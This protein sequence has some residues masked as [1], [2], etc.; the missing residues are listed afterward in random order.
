MTEENLA[1][2]S[3]QIEDVANPQSVSFTPDPKEPAKEPVKPPT[4]REA[5]EK[6]LAD[7]EAKDGKRLPDNPRDEKPE[8]KKADKETP[9][10]VKD[11]APAKDR[12]PDGKFA[13][14]Q[15]ENPQ[16]PQPENVNSNP[17]KLDAPK[18]PQGERDINRAPDN[19]LP[20]A[21]E[22]WAEAPEEVRGE[23]YR[24]LDN[25]EK[26]K[27]EYQEDREFRKSVREYEEL[28]TKA[29]V[30]FTDVLKNYVSIDN[31][32]HSQPDRALER[33]LGSIGLTPVQYAQ[34]VLGQMQQEQANP[35]LAHT[36]KLEQQVQQ[37]T[38]QQQQWIQQQQQMTEQQRQEAVVKKVEDDIITPFKANHPRYDELKDDIVFFLNSGRIPS[39]LS[40]Q[41]RLTEAYDMAERLNPAPNSRQNAQRP[42]NPA[43][44]KSIK[45]SLTN[46]LDIVSTKG[47]K[48]NSRDAINAAMEQLGL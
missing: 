39:T 27:Q 33:I 21:K 28:A 46:G 37:L 24:A 2:T 38:H 13:P 22:R 41:Q 1:A 14:K 6:S 42:I 11:E 31:D 8:A 25:F 43:G 40:V 15:P 35:A 34:Y 16:S 17:D 23:F 9:N 7:I 4:A 36:K 18:P 5:I 29:G 32:L 48:L 44:E 12:A 45:G 20:R 3:L 26:G 19:F 47:A 30:K 10:P